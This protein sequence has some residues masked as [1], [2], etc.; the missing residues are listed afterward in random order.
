[1]AIIAIIFLGGIFY[2]L[3]D[4]ESTCGQKFI[5]FIMLLVLTIIAVTC[6]N[7]GG[8]ADSDSFL[9]FGDV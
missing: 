5:K 8:S 2:I 3:S 7:M 6:S 1:M 9:K 4:E